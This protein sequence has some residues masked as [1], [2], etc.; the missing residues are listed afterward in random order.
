M[1]TTAAGRRGR[2]VVNALWV[3]VVGIESL[4]IERGLERKHHGFRT[5]SLGT[6]CVPH[7]PIFQRRQHHQGRS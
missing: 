3:V 1:V 5:W 6:L 4:R 2:S 7:P